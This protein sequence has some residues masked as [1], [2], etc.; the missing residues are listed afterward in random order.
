MYFVSSSE[1]GRKNKKVKLHASLTASDSSTVAEEIVVLIRRLHPLRAWN[2]LINNYIGASL[3][4]I[5]GLITTSSDFS[6]FKGSLEKEKVCR[7]T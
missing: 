7:F 6:Y 1:K 4:A 5:P 3:K 2:Q